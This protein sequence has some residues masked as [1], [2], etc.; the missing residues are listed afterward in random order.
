M[1]LVGVD[2]REWPIQNSHESHRERAAL[3]RSIRHEIMTQ[4]GGGN[5]HVDEG[6]ALSLRISSGGMLIFMEQVSSDETWALLKLGI[7]CVFIH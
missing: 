2:A 3:L 5:S 1:S 7:S 4:E 6:K